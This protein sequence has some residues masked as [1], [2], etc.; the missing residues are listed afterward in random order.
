MQPNSDE[1]VRFLVK[2]QRLLDE[3]S[4]V[5]S[6]K[7][8]LLLA[9][10]DLSVESGNDSGAPLVLHV[11][12]IAAKFIQYYW[13]Q[14][15]PYPAP[16]NA[17]ILSQNTGGQ[18]AILNAVQNART[19]YGDSFPAMRQHRAWSDLVRRVASTVDEMPLFRLQ[20]IGEEELDFLYENK[21]TGKTIEL[22]PGVAYCFRKFYGLI[23]DLVRNAWA[24]FVRQRNLKILGES[25][26]L[27]E[28]LF[29]SERA[30]LAAVRPVLLDLQ[31][32]KCFYCNASL[33]PA[34][35]EVDHFIA[36]SRYPV[37]LGHN[38]VLADRKC[39]QHKRDLLP[40]VS[41]LANWTERNDRYGGQ[42]NA[43]LEEKGIVTQLAASNQVARWAYTEAEEA[44]ALTWLQKDKMIVLDA[45]WR[46]LF[47]AHSQLPAHT[48]NLRVS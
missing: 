2:L 39:N 42:I 41:H 15:I 27:E 37:D 14:A 43:A 25:A 29:G 40:A 9:I 20:K 36:W 8:A 10:A 48:P 11:E 28:F 23:S 22:R 19:Q 35:A 1:Q 4:F 16:Q 17:R 21:R 13:K 33:R 32:G 44:S 3:G 30:S 47:D 46:G 38:F 7:F 6:Y 31:H 45:G 26:D 34:T 18:A 12:S 5:A 24:R